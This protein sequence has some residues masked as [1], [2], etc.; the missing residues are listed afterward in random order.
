MATKATITNM[1]RGLKTPLTSNPSIPMKHNETKAIWGLGIDVSK[2]TLNLCLQLRNGQLEERVVKNT[3]LAIQTLIKL[4]KTRHFTNKIV[5][6]STGRYHLLLAFLLS[7]ADFD[8]RVINPLQA[9]KY[10]TSSIRRNKTDAIDARHLAEMACQE[11]HLPKPFRLSQ[12]DIQLRQKIGL[13]ASLEK[14]VQTLTAIINNYQHFI[15]QFT[16]SQS[17]AEINL[18][19]LIK[20]LKKIKDQLE[21]EIDQTVKTKQANTDKLEF[22]KSIPG[23]S[24]FLACLIINFFSVADTTNPKQWIAYAGLDVSIRQSGL[25]KGRGKLSKRGNAYLRKRLFGGAWGATMTDQ[26][27]RR[28]YDQLKQQGRKHTEALL[29]ISRKLVTISFKLLHSNIFFDPCKAFCLDSS[30]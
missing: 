16:A 7:Q 28:W 14:Q 15:G 2:N 17:P 24:P 18:G 8:V 6:E 26:N 30:L 10:A 13:I 19:A 5:M 9:K 27:F 25:W 1:T 29:I 4:L 22:L 21:R 12:T 23:V 3:T 20:Q 11:N